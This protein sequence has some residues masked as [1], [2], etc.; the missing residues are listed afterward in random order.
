MPKEKENCDMCG[1]KIDHSIASYY[2]LC[3]DCEPDRCPVC[4][5]EYEEDD[6]RGTCWNCDM[7]IFAFIEGLI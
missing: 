5:Y 4:G 7:E 2:N 6:D 1:C 3:Y